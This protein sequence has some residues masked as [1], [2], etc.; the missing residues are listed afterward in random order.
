[1]AVFVIDD[2]LVHPAGEAVA[3][4]LPLDAAQRLLARV[5]TS[6]VPVHGAV[7][8][9]LLND[10]AALAAL[11][12]A[13]NEPPYKGAPK[14][15]VLYL[16]PR[17]TRIGHG[18]AVPVPEGVP[19]LATGPALGLVIG[20]TAC[21]VDEARALDFIAGCVVVND[22]SVPHESFYRPSVRLRARDGFCPVGPWVRALRHVGDP[23]TLQVRVWIDGEPVF[24]ASTRGRVRGAARLLAEVTDFMTLQ[25]GDVL[26]TGV[27]HG[28]PLARAG[29]RV[30]VEIEGVGRLENPLIAEEAL[31]PGAQA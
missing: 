17:N 28:A 8:G 24:T 10:P 14:A 13:V 21:R 2:T 30:A 26:L 31:F 11:G 7:Y 5:G 3:Q 15:P 29:Q 23:D 27:P 20:R 9:T 4:D 12:E 25:P 6:R 19:A 18:D 22:L 16:K 1:V